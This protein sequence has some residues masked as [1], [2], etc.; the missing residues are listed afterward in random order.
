[1]KKLVIILLI[2]LLVITQVFAIDSDFGGSLT[3]VTGGSFYSGENS[4]P[5]LQQSDKLS[6]WLKLPLDKDQTVLL[7]EGYYKFY[8][9]TS[10]RSVESLGTFVNLVDLS[11]FSTQMRIPLSNSSELSFNLGRMPMTDTSNLVFSQSIDALHMRYM[12]KNFSFSLLGAYT[13]FLNAATVG[14]VDTSFVYDITAIYPLNAPYA[15]GYTNLAFENIFPDITLNTEGFFLY[16]VT[17]NDIDMYLN[18]SMYGALFASGYFNLVTSVGLFQDETGAFYP[19]NL[20]KAEV[21][22]FSPAS[23]LSLTAFFTFASKDFVPYNKV[24]ADLSNTQYYSNLMKTGLLFTV[25]ATPQLPIVFGADALFTVADSNGA[26]QFSALQVYSDIKYQILSDVL[27]TFNFGSKVP[28]KAD[29]EAN[30][31][32]CTGQLNITF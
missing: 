29:T 16:A 20:S 5:V 32:Y 14:L 7:A 30:Y 18:A 9:D 22:L 21:S 4:T 24:Y 12:Y 19:T 1:M 28:I 10:T 25:K 26:T 13:G 31:F 17:N 27:L 2:C 23:V 8:L 6:L 15:V 11:L 3:N